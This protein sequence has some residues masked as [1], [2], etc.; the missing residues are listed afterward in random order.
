MYVCMCVRV[1]CTCCVQ[2][3]VCVCMCMCLCMCTFCFLR[4]DFTKELTRRNKE[5][6]VRSGTPACKRVKRAGMD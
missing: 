1:V 2:V 5:P 3:C 4:S 6:V